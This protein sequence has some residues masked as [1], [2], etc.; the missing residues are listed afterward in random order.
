MKIRW[1][2]RTERKHWLGWGPAPASARALRFCLLLLVVVGPAFG[3]GRILIVNS[4]QSVRKYRVAQDAFRETVS[5]PTKEIN[6]GDEAVGKPQ[7]NTLI[8]TQDPGL[9]YC[10]GSKAYAMVHGLAEDRKTVLSSV[11]NWQ[12]L[13]LGSRTYGIANELSAGM[14]LTM[15]RYLLPDVQTIG[16]LYSKNFN[17]EW[18][19][20]AK[21]DGE[22]TGV[23]IVGRAV[24]WASDV[25]RGLAKLLP[26]VDALWL[27]PDPTVLPDAASVR[28]I[29]A[30]CDAARKPIIAYNAAFVDQG[31][32]LAVSPDDP[33][34]GRQAAGLAETVLAAEEIEERFQSPAGSEI[35]LNMARVKKYG[36]KLNEDA[37][38]SVNRIIK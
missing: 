8:K 30:A 22:D 37:L 13:H 21:K 6:L 31:A 20:E 9:I 25:E 7:L 18:L 33:T 38:D 12:R 1:C 10:I 36:L 23:E 16:V 14:Q 26:K 24:R 29:F 2:G 4:D 27:I 17:Q 5:G 34:I 3:E 32:V 28:K 11:I 15:F 19:K 35:V